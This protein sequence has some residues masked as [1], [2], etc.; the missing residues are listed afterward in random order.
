MGAH[1]HAVEASGQAIEGDLSQGAGHGLI[2]DLGGEVRGRIAVLEGHAQGI[3]AGAGLLAGGLATHGPAQVHGQ[4]LDRALAVA[5]AGA[6]LAV[7]VRGARGSIG[8]Q[9]T[10][11]HGE[12]RQETEEAEEDERARQ[13]PTRHGRAGAHERHGRW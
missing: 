11:G 10:G 1:R 9:A 8:Q 4:E 13:G 7:R 2:D 3:D 5:R 12:R 6:A